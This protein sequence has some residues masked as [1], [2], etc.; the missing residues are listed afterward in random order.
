MNEQDIRTL[1]DTMK[2]MMKQDATCCL[3]EYNAF[4]IYYFV[5]RKYGRNTAEDYL[6]YEGW[7]LTAIEIL[8]EYVD[9]A[10]ELLR[11][12]NEYKTLTTHPPIKP[13]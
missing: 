6:L 10:E 8:D 5:L 13:L 12:L 3:P 1:Y 7:N 9:R 11:A 4:K 2:Q